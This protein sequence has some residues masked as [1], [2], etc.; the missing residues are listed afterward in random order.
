VLPSFATLLSPPR[1]QL[2]PTAAQPLPSARI[3]TGSKTRDH[4]RHAEAWQ[5]AP[6]PPLEK[7]INRTDV[8][9]G[10][11]S[12]ATRPFRSCGAIRLSSRPGG[13]PSDHATTRRATTVVSRRTAR[14]NL[15][16][17]KRRR[18]AGAVESL[19]SHRP[20]RN[21]TT[22]CLDDLGA[23]TWQHNRG[24]EAT[25]SDPI[26]ALRATPFDINPAGCGPRPHRNPQ[27]VAVGAED[28]RPAWVDS[29]RGPESSP[30]NAGKKKV[31]ADPGSRV[32]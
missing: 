24:V 22:Q 31:D 17:A 25:D 16:A 5:I 2:P 10:Q 7:P 32:R 6:A 1:V 14:A 29:S 8:P 23:R 9:A 19:G 30:T 27:H 21:T 12:P 3:P 18:L 4:H 15:M 28:S 11:G 20:E 13:Y 26:G